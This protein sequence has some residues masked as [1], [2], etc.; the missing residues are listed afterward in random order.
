M[1]LKLLF[2]VSMASAV[3]F[4]ETPRIIPH[5]IVLERDH[6][7]S[8]FTQGL[9]IRKGYFYESGGLYGDSVLVSYPVN[10]EVGGNW[11][12]P[13]TNAIDLDS[14]LFGEG[15]TVLKNRLYQLTWKE[16]TI[17]VYDPNTLS[18]ISTHAI[19]GEGW[20]LTTD[21]KYLIKSDGSSTI[22]FLN[23]DTFDVSKTITVTVNDLPQLNINELEYIDGF[24]FANIWH[25]NR[26]IKIDPSTGVAVGIVDLTDISQRIDTSAE[27]VLNGI[28]YD[29][30]RKAIWITGKKWSKMYLIKLLE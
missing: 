30:E 18:L 29:S 24:I 2:L 6:S 23:A 5:Q 25:D 15:L 12:R 8:V 14:R 22:T 27:R 20:G 28:A 3:C 26:V 10:D 19:A 17:L 9:V 11:L 16:K 21:G 1:K 13:F 7:T 4:G